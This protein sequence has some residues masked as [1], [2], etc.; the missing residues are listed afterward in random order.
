MHGDYFLSLSLTHPDV[1]GWVEIPKAVKISAEGSTTFSG[2]V[3]DYYTQ[4]AGWIFLE[5]AK[6]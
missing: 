6:G 1:C 4:N 3:F 5:E 2:R